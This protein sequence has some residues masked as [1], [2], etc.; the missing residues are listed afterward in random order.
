MWPGAQKAGLVP[1]D[2]VRSPVLPLTSCVKLLSAA[3]SVKVHN[4]FVHSA[5]S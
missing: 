4:N 1:N 3:S 5:E 2:L